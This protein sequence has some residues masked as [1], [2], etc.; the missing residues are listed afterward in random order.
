MCTADRLCEIIIN[1]IMLQIKFFDIEKII[2]YEFLPG[3][4]FYSLREN[5]KKKIGT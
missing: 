4:Q 5:L 1:E 2:Y 3:E